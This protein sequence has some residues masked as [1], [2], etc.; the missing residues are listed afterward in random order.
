MN[1][2]LVVFVLTWQQC[3]YAQQALLQDTCK[4]I[5]KQ[6]Q[7]KPIEPLDSTKQIKCPQCNVIGT[8]MREISVGNKMPKRKMNVVSV[9]LNTGTI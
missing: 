7:T 4:T 8:I 3:L 1:S 6:E 9:E 5:L 2:Y